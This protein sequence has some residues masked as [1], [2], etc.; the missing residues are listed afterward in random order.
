MS[1]SLSN[2][3]YK[4]AQFFWFGVSYKISQ[5][6]FITDETETVNLTVLDNIGNSHAITCSFD[7]F[8]GSIGI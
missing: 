1:V 4:G 2:K 8:H 3:I 6:Y 5:I 7:Q